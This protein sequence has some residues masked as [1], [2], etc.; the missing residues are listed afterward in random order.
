M[1]NASGSA[2]EYNSYQA[3]H[4]EP[5]YGVNY[6]RIKYVAANGQATYSKVE[7]VVFN[8]GTRDIY[9]YPNPVVDYTYV[10]FL[11]ELKE[12]ATIEVVDM[13]GRVLSSQVASDGFR[14]YRV[15]LADYPAGTYLIWVRYNDYRK[16]IERVIKITE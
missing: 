6:Y 9:V 2:L 8:N 5:Y 11:T 13:R 14:T 1:R 15:S 12:E 3:V 10:E 7:V 16:E 4:T